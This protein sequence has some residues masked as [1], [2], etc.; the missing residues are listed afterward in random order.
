MAT[1][2]RSARPAGAVPR[3]RVLALGLAAVVLS[4]AGCTGAESAPL[5]QR[6]DAVRLDHPISE[7]KW[8]G[9][10]LY[11][12]VEETRQVARIRLDGATTTDTRLSAPLS[13][14]GKNLAVTSE[15]VRDAVYVPQ[16]KRGRVVMLD[17]PGLTRQATFAAG[18]APEHVALDEGSRML[19]AL[20]ENGSAV[21]PIPLRGLTALPSREVHAGRHAELDGPSRG[22]PLDYYV[23]GPEGVAHYKGAPDRLER[24]GEIGVRAHTTAG[25]EVKPSRI[26]VAEEGTGRL[27]AIDVNRAHSGLHV[28]AEAELGEAVEHVAVDSRRVY[29]AT[30]HKLVVF[31]SNSFVGYENG[32]I[33]V[34]ETIHFRKALPTVALATAPLSGVAAGEDHVYMSFKTEP[35]LVSIE[36]PGI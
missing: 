27:L 28:V 18:R 7:P 2:P 34:V 9:G 5:P 36:K 33:P 12:L 4:V 20:S 25:D 31:E 10:A 23:A 22:R 29:A 11:G 35:Y 6:V 24:T 15:V 30:E 8:S 1:R 32:S 19:L 3:L 21:T 14:L 13:E 26:Y 16:P 17:A